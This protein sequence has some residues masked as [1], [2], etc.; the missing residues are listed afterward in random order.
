M[1]DEGLALRELKL[2]N[3][4]GEAHDEF[5]RVF[6]G[7]M[8]LEADCGEDGAGYG[9]VADG[10]GDAVEAV[11]EHAVDPDVDDAHHGPQDQGVRVQK[12]LDDVWLAGILLAGLVPGP[13]YSDEDEHE[14]GSC[15]VGGPRA[16]TVV[17]HVRRCQGRPGKKRLTCS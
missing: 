10:G 17:H 8:D 5:R 6:L 3:G 12:D 9:G 14:Y 11:D 1:G 4:P 7:E 15:S 2:G 16:G 13:C